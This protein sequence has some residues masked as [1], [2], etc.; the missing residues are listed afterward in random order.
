MQKPKSLPPLSPPQ[1][2]IMDIV[3]KGNEITVGEVWGILKD[4]RKVARNTIQ[5]TMSRLAE[6]GWLTYR[7]EGNTFVY[8]ATQPREQTRRHTLRSLLETAFQGSTE[9]L[10]LTLL[11][12]HTLSTEELSR[13]KQLIQDAEE[14]TPRATTSDSP[15]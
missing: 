9:G 4:R 13:I 5:T 14:G 15:S 8:K 10:L 11:G 3:W 6:K 12:D 2:E 7:A 1:W